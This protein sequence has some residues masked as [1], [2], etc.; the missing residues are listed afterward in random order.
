MADR[1]GKRR[2]V[3]IGL[4]ISI[5]GFGL[6]ATS[7]PTVAIGV[8]LLALAL[9]GFEF[10]IVSAIPLATELQPEARARYLSWFIVAMALARTVGAAIGPAIFDWTGL[11]GVAVAAVAVDILALVVLL[12]RLGIRGPLPGSGQPVEAAQES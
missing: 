12:T 5:I 11:P 8:G 1:L 2:S 7:P 9:F 3:A 6:L 4:V 10:T